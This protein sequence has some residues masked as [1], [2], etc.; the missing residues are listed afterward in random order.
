MLFTT[1]AITG[2][3][4]GVLTGNPI[5]AFV[6][7]WISH[8]ILDSLPH[9]DQGSFYLEKDKGPSWLGIKQ[10]ESG[11]KF[12]ACPRDWIIL[13]FD[14]F[15]AG[16][17]LLYILFNISFSLWLILFFGALGG[18]LPDILDVS[19]FW[20]KKFKATKIGG[21]FHQFHEF[22]HWPL[23]IKWIYLGIAIQIIIVAIDL[24][25]IG[26]FF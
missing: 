26:K 13:F 6:F 25:Y 12:K 15:I 23:T 2:I 5:L 4:I 19:P 3:T 16:I 7:G 17:L 22:F 8:H 11:Q 1:H 10:K 9:F 21:K 20:N 18:L 14:I 24:F